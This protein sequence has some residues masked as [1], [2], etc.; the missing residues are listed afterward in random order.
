MSSII[1]KSKRGSDLRRW[2]LSSDAATFDGVLQHITE[3]Y[4]V[5]SSSILVRYCDDEGDWVTLSCQADLQEAISIVTSASL[6]LGTK[7]I[8]RLDVSDIAEVA[9][10]PAAEAKPAACAAQA[11]FEKEARKFEKEARKFE[12]EAEKA[13]KKAAREVEKVARKAGE[14]FQKQMGTALPELASALDQ[15]AQR[16][17]LPA[18]MAAMMKHVAA[19][20]TPRGTHEAVHHG[21]S[22]DVSGMAPIVGTRYK[23][24]GENY[25]LC[26]AEFLKLDE[27]A[28]TLFIAIEH[29]QQIY[30]PRCGRVPEHVKPQARFV[31][32]VNIPDNTEILPGTEFVKIWKLRNSG[33][34]AWPA[35]T[36][37][38]QVGGDRFEGDDCAHVSA[39]APNAETEVAVSLVAPSEPG[40]YVSY[41]RLAV[42][43]ADGAVKRKF[44]QRVWVQVVI[45]REDGGIE[46]EE[47]EQVVHHG[48]ACDA[49]DQCPITGP[50][51]HKKGEDYDLCEAEFLKLS[52]QAKLAFEC[53]AK[54]G[55]DPV[56]MDPAAPAEEP[57]EVQD[58]LEARH[59]WDEA[60]M[61]LVTNSPLAALIESVKSN[62]PTDQF[63][64]FAATLEPLFAVPQERLE[65]CVNDAAKALEK[66]LKKTKPAS[67]LETTQAT[68]ETI[69][70]K[71][72]KA[73]NKAQAKL[74]AKV[75]KE[76]AKAAKKEADAAKKAAKAEAEAKKKAAK[77]EA[78]EAAK[79]AAK[80]EAE[81]AAK[82]A[83]AAKA[84]AEAEAEDAAKAEVP[85]TPRTVEDAMA[86]MGLE[87]SDLSASMFA[88]IEGAVAEN[89]V[90]V[91]PEPEPEPA[92][93]PEPEP[94]PAPEPEPVVELPVVAEV[95]V[96][97]QQ[98]AVQLANMGFEQDACLAALATT[99]NDLEAALTHLLEE[100]AEQE[101]RGVP[102]MPIAEPAEPEL[103][104]LP[105]VPMDMPADEVSD[106][107]PT[108]AENW[109][110]EWDDLLGELTEMGFEDET[111]NRSL[112]ASTN[113]NIKDA[114]K[115]LVE[116]ERSAR[117][118]I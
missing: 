53:I 84:A 4:S 68:V 31:E 26:E 71:V 117:Q 75:A 111:L 67:L 80:A 51:Y 116:K 17:D 62:M 101:R 20:M 6:P 78:K 10:P 18:P 16:E 43:G 25:D 104:E 15:A 8:L 77:A 54:P 12:K 100:A 7:A 14:E 39:V 108:E 56:D 46:F 76:E 60:T 49:S 109:Q 11:H 82:E 5:P 118:Q 74:E 99:S 35:S 23:K 86:E 79:E 89:P 19:A 37:L 96:A 88:E 13:A 81:A 91:A 29:P 45:V 57:N 113:G 21:V 107:E 85:V 24:R 94:E 106:E 48:V 97:T 110:S 98:L 50:R 3:L 64:Q 112:I 92:P 65:Q 87:A 90:I 32:H 27:Q 59:G 69:L 9:E 28:K 44:G 2:T 1:F 70:H 61:M 22:C 102:P 114:V 63:A 30:R 40:R 83:E 95:D 52:D 33:S 55:D 103:L 36:C 47:S 93:E 66:M 58:E 115:E 73:V 72:N 34:D 41:W 105:P 38:I 42:K